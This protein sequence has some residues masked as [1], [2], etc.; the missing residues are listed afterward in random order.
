MPKDALL[1]DIAKWFQ[2]R[3]I[4]CLLCDP[5]S[6]GTSDGEPRN[7][8]SFVGLRLPSIENILLTSM[9]VFRLTQGS[10]PK[11]STTP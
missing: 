4:T 10:K 5:R 7:D 9:P 3:D 6:I 8:V 2:E 1:P 11:I